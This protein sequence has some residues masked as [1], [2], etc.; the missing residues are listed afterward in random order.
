MS[1]LGASGLGTLSVSIRASLAV[2]VNVGLRLGLALAGHYSSGWLSPLLHQTLGGRC[3]AAVDHPS[4]S[5]DAGPPGFTHQR[6]KHEAWVGAEQAG[7][8]P[9]LLASNSFY[10]A[11]LSSVLG[12][13]RQRTISAWTQSLRRV[14]AKLA[15]DGRGRRTGQCSGGRDRAQ[16]QRG[17]STHAA[18]LGAYAVIWL[19][20]RRRGSVHDRLPSA[21][22]HEPTVR[23]QHGQRAPQKSSQQRRKTEGRTD[24]LERK[25]EKVCTPL[26]G[27]RAP[28][29]GTQANV[30][31]VEQPRHQVYNTQRRRRQSLT[32]R[33]NAGTGTSHSSAQDGWR[34][35]D[36]PTATMTTPQTNNVWSTAAEAEPRHPQAQRRPTMTRTPPVVSRA[37]TEP[38]LVAAA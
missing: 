2:L 24:M 32:W 35:V 12:R 29:E 13:V 3:T 31:S 21:D 1:Q 17:W 30:G 22:H 23:K 9:W 8:D 26:C 33:A 27:S 19:E 7:A 37:R 11:G 16:N 4:L 38:Q 15:P 18:A 36:A 6:A 14:G 34:P 5:G 20:W 25:R 10:P 28:S